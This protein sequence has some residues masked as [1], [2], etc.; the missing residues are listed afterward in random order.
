MNTIWELMFINIKRNKLLSIGSFSIVLLVSIVLFLVNGFGAVFER[1]ISSIEN[2]IDVTLFLK[3]TISLDNSSL[4]S[5]VRD[6]E[7][8]GFTVKKLS[9][10]EA[11]DKL[12]ANSSV[13]D[14]IDDTAKFVETY[15][16]TSALLPI[17]IV[18]GIEKAGSDKLKAIIDNP[19][20]SSLLDSS[21]IDEQL[22]R[23]TSFS[24]LA[25]LSKLIYF[26]FYILFLGVAALIIFNTTR[27]L[28]YSRS[29]EIEIM[30]L[31]GA[32]RKA[33]ELPFYLEMLVIS[34]AGVVVSFLIIFGLL[35]QFNLFFG[36]SAGSG[37]QLVSSLAHNMLLFFSNSSIFE[38]LRM[39]VLFGIIS[40]LS[41]WFALRSYLPRL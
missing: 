26:G 14:L 33:I 27:I 5:M 29:K 35:Y 16:N 4:G 34:L 36:V 22:S 25:G 12:K 40:I 9:S 17:L 19:V 28:I 24:S 38:L 3:K 37:A 23:A 15:Q 18:S 8:T 6:L 1:G 41:V 31:V 21:Y 13:P 30:E 2:T 32:R 39:M 20:Y 11:L 10:K 7:A